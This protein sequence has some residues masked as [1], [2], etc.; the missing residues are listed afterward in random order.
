MSVIMISCFHL[1]L[2]VVLLQL[3][4]YTHAYDY[5]QKHVVVKSVKYVPSCPTS[6]V[7]WDKAASKKRCGEKARQQNCT[8]KKYEY[9]CVINEYRNATLEV[10]APQRLILGHCTEFNAVGGIIQD[11]AHN[12]SVCNDFFP[13]CDQHYFST[14]A[15]KY[16]DCYQLVKRS[17]ITPSIPTSFERSS[18]ADSRDI[19]IIAL[20]AVCF[21][22]I[23]FV[24]V[25]L[26]HIYKSSLSSRHH[27]NNPEDVHQDTFLMQNTDEG[28]DDCE[29]NDI[30]PLSPQDQHMNYGSAL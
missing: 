8:T 11:Q 6:K 3:Q 29:G 7:H 26:R 27:S 5:C 16:Q 19:I 2:I 28:G 22:L 1:F 10:C 17:K 21:I 4:S 20:T 14:D 13:R 25:T 15:Y 23:A 12:D 9:H 30:V 18:E 24:I